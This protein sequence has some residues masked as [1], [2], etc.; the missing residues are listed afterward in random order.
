MKKIFS[1]S[2]MLI[3][4]SGGDAGAALAA[5]VQ[6][7]AAELGKENVQKIHLRDPC[8]DGAELQR[9]FVRAAQQCYVRKTGAGRVGKV[10]D[11]NGAQAALARVRESFDQILCRAGIGE[12]ENDV[13]LARSSDGDG[14]HMRV[15]HGEELSA[16]RGK[17]MRRLHCDDHGAALSHAQH[18]VRLLQKI[19]RADIFLR[20]DKLKRLR[21]GADVGRVELFADIGKAVVIEHLA[22]ER[23]GLLR[24]LGNSA[25]PLWFLGAA[26][27]GNVLLDLLFT[28]SC[29][30]LSWKI[31]RQ[32]RELVD[33]RLIVEQ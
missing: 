3:R 29:A 21:H 24:A 7:A 11:E 1:R 9:A 28:G 19:R 17:E 20:T 18:P 27:V 4:K 31:W 22:G 16:C 2:Q 26:A 8:A 15:G 30:W 5:C 12:E 6:I 13:V 33:K 32:P 10:C 14:L 25:A 23:V